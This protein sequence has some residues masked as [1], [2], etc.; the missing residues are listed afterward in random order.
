ML[1]KSLGSNINAIILF[2]SKFYVIN[3]K[4]KGFTLKTVHRK[5]D[6]GYKNS[7]TCQ[8]I[9]SKALESDDVLSVSKTPILMSLCI[10]SHNL[11]L[12]EYIL[13]PLLIQECFM[14]EKFN[15]NISECSTNKDHIT[16]LLKQWI[17]DKTQYIIIHNGALHNTN[18]LSPTK[19]VFSVCIFLT[20]IVLL[21]FFIIYN[22]SKINKFINITYYR[23]NLMR[24]ILHHIHHFR[25]RQ[26]FPSCSGKNKTDIIYISE[27]NTQIY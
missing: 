16:S 27:T 20:T 11:N 14:R 2:F 17:K 1:R 3:F 9:I 22:I 25:T 23:R 12:K 8:T 6:K 19:I 24:K 13:P 4:P 21:I 26:D 18:I 10:S 5:Y 7:E 15:N